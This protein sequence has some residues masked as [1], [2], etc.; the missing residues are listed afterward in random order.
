MLRANAQAMYITPKHVLRNAS[1]AQ[2]HG[3]AHGAPGHAHKA[4]MPFHSASMHAHA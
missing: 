4:R 3:A 2:T 1:Y